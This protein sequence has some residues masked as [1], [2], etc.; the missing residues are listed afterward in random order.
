MGGELSVD[1]SGPFLKSLPV[2][3]R[4][5]KEDLWPRYIVVGAFTA[6]TPKEAEDRCEK[7]RRNRIAAGL[8]GPVQLEDMVNKQ[9][10]L[11]YFRHKRMFHQQ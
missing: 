6:Y 7:E 10:D 8:E 1:I 4:R 11:L 3:D 2:T 5:E 9:N